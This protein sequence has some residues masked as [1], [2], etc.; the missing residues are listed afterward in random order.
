MKNLVSNSL[1][2]IL[3]LTLIY[4]L[5]SCGGVDEMVPVFPQDG[6]QEDEDTIVEYSA[7]LKDVYGDVKQA[8]ILNSLS[9]TVEVEN[10]LTGFENL[11]VNGIRITIFPE[12]ENQNE[13]L[14][15]YLHARAKA[16]GFKIMANPALWDGAV[17]I[18]NKVLHGTPLDPDNQQNIGPAS[19]LGNDEATQI[20]IDR[21]KEFA[22][23]YEVDYITPFNEDGSP[24]G[25]WTVAQF[26]TIYEELHNDINGAE[27][28]GP[29]T[30]GIPSGTNVLQQTNISEYITVAT[31]H[32]LGFNHNAWNGFINAAGDLPVWDS[33][34]NNNAAVPDKAT[35]LDAAI[36]AGVDGL[37]LYDSWRYISL[38][39]GQLNNNGN[40]VKEKILE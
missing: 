30:W 27:L 12:G 19:T 40:R 16:K 33:E 21:I 10:L 35:R 38:E 11:G 32:N 5:F 3:T 7:N 39:N 23:K 34:V 1:M 29:C 26:N 17:R 18:V 25:R 6:S 8:Q 4:T 2:K 13:E 9:T 24:G 37:V 36:D 20:L 28:M 14:F 15:D 31:T 22:N